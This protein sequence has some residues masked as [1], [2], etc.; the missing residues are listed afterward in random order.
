MT[1]PL[2]EFKNIS[3]N[4]GGVRALQNVSFAIPQGGV[5]ALVGEN[6]AGKSTLIKVIGGVL[7]PDGGTIHFD[8]QDI[9]FSNA[10]EARGAGIAIVHQEI[11]VCPHMT[12][13]ENVFLGHELP[14]RFGI[15]NWGEVNRRAQSYFDKFQADINPRATVGA[16]PIAKQQM[17]EIAQALSQDAK[18]LIMD[19]PTSALG[20]QET[21]NLFAIIRDLVKHGITIV[22][23]SHRLEE[24]FEI[25]DT[26]TALRDGEYVGSAA[27]NAVT[28][29]DV[30]SMMVGREITDLFPKEY[31]H[32]N[33]QALLSVRNLRQ[34]GK[35]ENVSFDLHPGEVLGLVGL[36]GSGASE[37][38]RALFGS[39]ENHL[40]GDVMVNGNAVS[41]RSPLDAIKQGIA[42]IPADRQGE[43]L[44]SVMSVR[45]NSGMLILERIAR[46]LGWVPGRA[47]NQQAS[48]AVEAFNIRTPSIHNLISSLS[49]G[50]Q[51]KVV[52]SKALSTKPLVILMDDPT[53]GVDV[54][55]KAEIHHIL[56]QITAQGNAII[57]ASSELPEVLAMSDRVIVMYKGEMKATLHHS[58]ADRDYVMSLATGVTKEAKKAG[59]G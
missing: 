40:H 1:T 22:Y 2:I 31:H 43:G 32:Q 50:N 35:F 46:F 3:K 58:E 42:Y 29:D 6:G 52:V 59:A 49:G 55:A 41:I 11:P 45:D 14:K 44:F 36:Q 7:Q 16:L 39:G 10:L 18:L 20:K 15:I 38:M 51:Q 4:F 28:P 13:A 26:V 56:N 23:V 30:V 54:G 57:M 53:R 24:V 48:S 47:L 5:H 12:A 33:A 17:I 34:E 8:G 19:E 27:I 37:I 21:D 25:A 9:N